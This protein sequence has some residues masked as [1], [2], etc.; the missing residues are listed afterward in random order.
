MTLGLLSVV[1]CSPFHEALSW[2]VRKR[3]AMNE[4]LT[5]LMQSGER[6]FSLYLLNISHNDIHLL[7]QSTGICRAV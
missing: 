1:I 5:V 3:E 4:I 7:S 6:Q 2:L